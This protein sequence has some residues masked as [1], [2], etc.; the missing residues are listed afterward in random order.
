MLVG[1]ATLLRGVPTGLV[2]MV[3]HPML[4]VGLLSCCCCSIAADA[5]GVLLNNSCSVAVVMLL[6]WC[7]LHALLVPT[8]VLLRVVCSSESSCVQCWLLP[9]M[10]HRPLKCQP[11]T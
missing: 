8:N 10:I 7:T 4:A 9:T 2:F 5:A 3:D 11:V 6:S 1:T